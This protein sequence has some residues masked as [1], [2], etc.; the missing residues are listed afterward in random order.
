MFL[1]RLSVPLTV[2]NFPP[3]PLSPP[4]VSPAGVLQQECCIPTPPF[5]KDAAK[6]E[7]PQKPQMQ[8][9]QEAVC[10]MNES[11]HGRGKEFRAYTH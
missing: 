2:W 8:Q 3:P 4:S 10:E 1:K 7:T 5:L 11:Q 9:W 6:Q